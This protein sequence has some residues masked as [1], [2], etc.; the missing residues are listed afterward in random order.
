[1]ENST[2][3]TEAYTP[4]ASGG[5]KIIVG[6]G[7]FGG[8]KGGGSGG[9]EDP[10]SLRSK[11]YAN[12]LFLLGEGEIEGPPSGDLLRDLYFDE[13]PVRSP[14]GQLNFKDF[15]VEYR[16]G[17]Q[18]QSYIPGIGNDV[19]SEDAINVQVRRNV[20]P[21]VRAIQNRDANAVR[22]RVFAP[23]LQKI[24]DKGNIKGNRV[25]FSIELSNNGGPFSAVPGS[26]FT[27]EGKKTGGYQR[28]YEFRLPAGGPWEV[29][30]TRLTEDSE[31]N[32]NQNDLYFQA[33]TT[34]IEAKLRYP[35]SALL[36]MRISAEQF[37]S[38]P[39][40][41]LR[42]RL[43]KVRVPSNYD[44]LTRVYSPAIWDGT[45]RYAWTDNPAW[46][47][48]DLMT[49]ERYGAG[50][51][52]ALGQVDKWSFYQIARYCDELVPDG[53][54]GQEPR[55]TCN[56]YIRNDE[57]AYTL[58]N[59]LASVFRG[60]LYWHTGSI[61][62]VQ[63]APSPPV[64]LYTEANVT[65]EVDDEGNVTRPTFSYQGTGLK[66]RHTVALVTYFD[67][68]DFHRQKVEY[69]EDP[70]AIA[71][72]GY[73]PTEITAFGCASQAQAHRVG[74]W[75]LF[76]EQHETDTLTFRVASEGLLVRP[77]E[78]IKIADP[79]R[80][81]ER[82]GGRIASATATSVVLDAPVTLA[83]GQTYTLS[84]LKPDL[85]QQSRVVTTPA[86]TTDTLEVSSA[87]DELPA[88]H[89][90]WVLESTNLV[91]QQFRVLAVTEQDTEYELLCVEHNPS[92]YNHIDRDL[93]LQEPPISTLP[94][95][96]YI[97]PPSS[98]EAVESLYSTLGSAGVRTQVQLLWKASPSV[99]VAS[100][101]VEY[102]APDEFE[103]VVLENTSNTSALL[104]D[105]Q[106]GQYGFRVKAIN[107]LGIS[108]SYIETSKE[109]YGLTLPPANVTNFHLVPLNNQ[110]QLSWSPTLDLDVQVGGFFR[111]KHSPKL[112]GATWVEG[113]EM[114]QFSGITTTGTVPLLSGTYMIKAV[115]S[116]GNESLTA[117]IALTDV[118][119]VLAFNNVAALQEH[120]S[121][122]G[123]KQGTVVDQGRLRLDYQQNF[124][125]D[126]T[127]LFDSAPG[128]FDDYPGPEKTGVLP[129]GSYEFAGS[130]DLGEVF[131]SRV[132][133]QIGATIVDDVSLF[134]E[135]AGLFDERSGVFDGTDLSEGEAILEVATS[136]N[137]VDWTPYQPF[138]VG[139][140]N[141][142]GFKFRARLLSYSPTMNIYVN[143]LSVTVDMPDRTEAGVDT[144]PTTGLRVEFAFPFRVAPAVGITASDLQQGDHYQI[145]NRNAFGFDIQFFNSSGTAISKTFSWFAS[146]YGKQVGLWPVTFQR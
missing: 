113:I 12:V 27:I 34:I 37:S 41:A 89:S 121:F 100:Y 7:G 75:L 32:K 26:P 107:R 87:F 115:D 116:S 126:Y 125:A 3:I 17:T 59:S 51:R 146:G 145:T 10:E 66:A 74:E 88:A 101:Q 105:A 23:S 42:L 1:M 50:T 93:I 9:K 118:P 94:N 44:P 136:D 4:L 108:S 140:Y 141:A 123:P 137:F 52:I 78:I 56:C 109:I 91:A 83:A 84:V 5:S 24:D 81:G 127:L 62:A 39:S 133:A 46:I 68:K 117:A 128:L 47:L 16:P 134:D 72:Y 79:L 20:G 96:F 67:P 6:S 76:S 18:A 60:M 132:T 38:I 119:T 61:F 45:F 130:I 30:M 82:R 114:A 40:V 86:G 69:V 2:D 64:R 19:E 99:T 97:E 25:Q 144:V 143:Q 14:S 103:W 110:A 142:R 77:G 33:L 138:F 111:I 48:F 36:G 102:R 95:L 35:N 73:R 55:F 58:L 43:L 98:L 49:H 57:A 104:K 90:I 131:V 13:T 11:A 106:T 21:V 122:T 139:D 65:Q 15:T 31:S 135:I 70:E 54:G 129:E 29:R 112:V 124:D 71:R 80:A 28:S 63:D 8:G 120:P 85:S 92:K 22:V 53:R